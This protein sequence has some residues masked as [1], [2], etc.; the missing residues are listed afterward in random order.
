MADPSTLSVPIPLPVPSALAPVGAAQ[1]LPDSLYAPPASQTVGETSTV[2]NPPPTKIE[3]KPSYASSGFSGFRHF[4][5]IIWEEY[6]SDLTGTDRINNLIRMRSEGSIESLFN[7]IRL[8]LI[9][10]SWTVEPADKSAQAQADADWVSENLM[11][12][13]GACWEDQVRQACNYLLFGFQP[14]AKEWRIEDGKVV[15]FELRWLHPLTVMQGGKRWDF[16]RFGNVRG[17]WQ[18]GTD[19]Y[20]YREEYVPAESLLLFTNDPDW[21]NPEGRSLFRGAWK[22]YKIIDVLDRIEAIGLERSAI[23]TPVGIAPPG[24]SGDNK[25][26]FENFLKFMQAQENGYLMLDM[27]DSVDLK[28]IDIRKLLANFSVDIKTEEIKE[29]RRSHESRMARSVLAQFLL[30]GQQGSG[31]AYSLGADQSDLFLVCLQA[32]GDYIAARFNNIRSGVIPEMVAY[33]FGPR[34]AYPKLACTISQKDANALATIVPALITSNA[35]SWDD[36]LE[37]HLRETL[38]FPELQGTPQADRKK[39]ADAAAKSAQDAMKQQ[40]GATP[41]LPRNPG[42]T[43]QSRRVTPQEIRAEM[44][45]LA[46]ARRLAEEQG[47]V[48]AEPRGGRRTFFSPASRTFP[49][50][51]DP[52]SGKFLPGPHE[53]EAAGKAKEPTPTKSAKSILAAQTSRRVAADVQRYSEEHCEG[54]LAHGLREAGVHAASLKDNEPVDILRT[55]GGKITDGVELKTATDNKN[56]RVTMKATAI[57]RKSAWRKENRADTHTVVFDDTKVKDAHGPG[58]HDES[59]RVIYY[60]RGEANMQHTSMHRVSDMAELRSLV[61]MKTSDLPAKAKPPRGYE[62]FN[63]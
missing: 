20:V 8:P 39:A 47:L 49:V 31:G 58:K 56:G 54:Q 23:G 30:L 1:T 12:R 16:D 2:P 32:I 44:F 26:Q 41:Q 38:E 52:H 55:V 21:Q 45:D 34:K 9:G 46:Q 50:V 15:L 17:L 51:H 40:P 18:Y 35:L 29:A 10:A 48:A 59:A 42:P 63:P 43:Q 11:S 27:S 24:S 7:A 36:A 25:E 6:L 62:G 22:H 57:A 61:K 60:R 33:N 37:A 13:L 28:D 5:G 4:R 14:A 3:A 53:S 19:G